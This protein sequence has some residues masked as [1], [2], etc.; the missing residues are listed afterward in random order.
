MN[1]AASRTARTVLA[2]TALAS[3]ACSAPE[4]QSDL[5]HRKEQTAVAQ[6]RA[7]SALERDDVR[8]ALRQYQLALDRSRA[9]EDQD[10]TATGLLNIAA[11][12]HRSGDFTAARAK[13]IE[14]LEHQPPFVPAYAGRAEARL[15][16]IELQTNRVADAARHAARAQE[17]CPPACPWQL[18]LLVVEAGIALRSGDPAGAQTRAQAAVDAARAAKDIREEANAWR[19]LGEAAGENGRGTQARDAFLAALSLDRKAE[20]P[21]RIALDLLALARLELALGN[22]G[23]AQVYARRAAEVAEGA[24]LAAPLAAARELE[25][26][27]Q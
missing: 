24:R 23:P 20:L 1:A 15:A 17:L 26:S 27:A 7:E 6:Q 11:V 4:P 12:L 25:R 13:L 5:D 8:G 2:A 21:E 14:L 22:R 3:A 16:L 10:A 18:P 9:V 19:L